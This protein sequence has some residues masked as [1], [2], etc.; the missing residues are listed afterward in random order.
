MLC[1]FPWL[2][3]QPPFE[4][5]QISV[6]L[7]IKLEEMLT[8]VEVAGIALAI[9]P[10]CITI[11]EHHE[12]ELRPFVALLKYRKVYR[13]SAE[14]LGVCLVQLEQIMVNLFREAGISDD[15]HDIKALVQAYDA[16]AW[17]G[18]TEKKLKAHFG[19]TVY[20]QGVKVKL[21]RI[22]NDVA[23]ISSILDLGNLGTSAG[24]EVTIVKS[25]TI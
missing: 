3:T 6:I 9:A 12:A 5:S 25:A 2:H 19:P 22:R 1:S 20:E 23:E 11:L 21:C 16:T 17:K 13:R 10:L 24:D 18:T 14:D 7:N 4:V 8:G 15:G